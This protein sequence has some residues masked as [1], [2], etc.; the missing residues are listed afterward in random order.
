MH[1][2]RAQELSKLCFFRTKASVFAG[3]HTFKTPFCSKDW[4]SKKHQWDYE[5]SWDAWEHELQHKEETCSRTKPNEHKPLQPCTK[6]KKIN[7]A[8]VLALCPFPYCLWATQHHLSHLGS[9][10]FLQVNKSIVYSFWL[11]QVSVRIKQLSPTWRHSWGTTNSNQ[12]SQ[13]KLKASET[14][15]IYFHILSHVSVLQKV[16]PGVQTFH[17]SLFPPST[18]G[19]FEFLFQDCVDSE[20]L[21][22]TQRAWSDKKTE[23]FSQQLL[24]G[25]NVS[26]KMKPALHSWKIYYNSPNAH[27]GN[28][29]TNQQCKSGLLSQGTAPRKSWAGFPPCT[30]INIP[31]GLY[32]LCSSKCAWG[33]GTL[34]P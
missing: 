8:P 17:T 9:P 6:N 32:T 19:L 16:A 20:P 27:R 7:H 28:V 26:N 14:K 3:S 22:A 18:A 1:T 10:K 12:E 25:N 29:N 31:T 30:L 15:I 33:K 34:M 5:R 24:S 11:L 13:R 4:D 2:K 21:L 23:V